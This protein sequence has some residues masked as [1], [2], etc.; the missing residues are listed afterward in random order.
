MNNHNPILMCITAETKKHRPEPVTCL[1]T[2]HT[3]STHNMSTLN[4]LSY[5]QLYIFSVDDFDYIIVNITDIMT[6]SGLTSDNIEQRM[7]ID[8][9]IWIRS[10]RFHD[11]ETHQ[12]FTSIFQL[13]DG[14]NMADM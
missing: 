10:S 11:P 13:Q 1:D 12:C 3:G 7:C 14:S 5:S 9:N 4:Q 2:S 6:K 8:L